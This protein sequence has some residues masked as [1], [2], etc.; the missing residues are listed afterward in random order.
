MLLGFLENAA[1]KH[2]NLAPEES[3][4]RPANVGRTLC[5]CRILG[6]AIQAIGGNEV[7]QTRDQTVIPELAL[8]Y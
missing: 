2:S 4:I 6:S 7:I 1:C 3:D 8:L 5:N